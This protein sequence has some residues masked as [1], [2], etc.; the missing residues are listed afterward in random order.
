MT[1]FVERALR[2]AFATTVPVLPFSV[3][4][5]LKRWLE[6]FRE[7]VLKP[8]AG[9]VIEERRAALAL[10][11]AA[12]IRA[13]ESYLK[14]GLQAAER[15]DAEREQ[16]RRAVFTETVHVAVIREELR[17]AEEKM[18]SEARQAFTG[19]FLARRATVERRMNT[20]LAAELRTWRGNL[21]QQARRYETWMADRLTA[22]LTPLSR[23]AVPLA[24]DLLGQTEERFRRVVQAFRD[25]LG[26]NVR[27]ALGITLAPLAWEVKRP[28]LNL[29]PV[30]LSQTFMTPWELLWWLLPMALVGGLFRRHVL[31]RIPWEVE[32]NLIRL[33]GDWAETVEAAIAALRSQAA[34]GVDDELATLDQLLGRQPAETAAFRNAFRRLTGEPAA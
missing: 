4:V 5:E 17:L 23:D 1:A 8:L 9:N 2:E 14:V 25:R 21:A 15:M 24:A 31:G 33:A 19:F 30:A 27:E 28:E 18:R 6:Q 7:A 12:L 13:C 26:S 32:K 34:A 3:R 20:A 22:E 10:K 16:L 29:V 11:T